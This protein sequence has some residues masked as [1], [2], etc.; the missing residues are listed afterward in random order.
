[1][2]IRDWS[3][4][5]CSSDLQLYVM[6]ADGSGQQR[7]SFGDGRYGTPVWSPRGDLIAFT[8]MGGGGF[9]IGVIRPDGGGERILTNA[10]QDEGPSWS[11]NGRV[12]TFFRTAQGSGKADL[13][14]IE[15]RKSTRL[16]SSHYCAAR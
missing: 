10:W 12:I 5:V 6:N 13:W 11:P 3:S 14:S 2:R 8:K 1:M 15:D 9:R 4:D 7:V 16:N